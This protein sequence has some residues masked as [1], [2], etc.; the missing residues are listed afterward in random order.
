MSDKDRT[1]EDAEPADAPKPLAGKVCLVAGAARGVGRGVALAL[2][3][4]DWQL[5]FQSRV[6]P[7]PWLQ[8][9]T[10]HTLKAWG[11]A[12]LQ[13]VQ[14]VCP[15]FPT[16][17]LE[18]LEEIAGENREYFE[19]AGGGDYRF[20]PGLN[21]SPSHMEFYAGLAAR[22]CQGWPEAGE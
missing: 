19:Q 3:E 12:G 14:V 17:C 20:I 11:K 1:P 8:P 5:S 4:A 22:H 6:G 21:A 2:G 9:Y 7:K 13:R 16:D 10:D 15:G 18:T